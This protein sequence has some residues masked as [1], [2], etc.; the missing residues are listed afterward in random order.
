MHG[1]SELP[2]CP[3]SFFYKHIDSEQ[4]SES[5]NLKR[6]FKFATSIQIMYIPEALLSSSLIAS[7]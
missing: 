5:P 3:L 6:I 7:L 1:D 4:K 2:V